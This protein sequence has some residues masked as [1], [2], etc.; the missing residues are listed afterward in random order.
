MR[1]TILLLVS[2]VVLCLSTTPVVADLSVVFDSSDVKMTILDN[3]GDGTSATAILTAESSASPLSVNIL[4]E[5]TPIDGVDLTG[6]D[7]DFTLSLVGTGDLYTASGILKLWDRV[8]NTATTPDIYGAF[9]STLVAYTS[10]GGGKIDIDGYLSPV[11]GLPILRNTNPW[12]FKGDTSDIV[13]GDGDVYADLGADPSSYDS[14]FV[15]TWSVPLVVTGDPLVGGLGA[16]TLESLFSADNGRMFHYG[17]VQ[18]VVVPVP[19]A[20]LLGILGLSVAGL[21]LRKRA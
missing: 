11:G 21:K 17:D 14:G 10:I 3:D 12:S 4:D 8:G 16:Q 6:F 15:W 7:L 20:V 13:A 5:T 18:G 19:G 1:K 2:I 9:T